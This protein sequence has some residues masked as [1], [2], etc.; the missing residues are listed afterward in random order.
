MSVVR[1]VRHHK[2]HVADVQPKL[3]V[4][5]VRIS[6]RDQ[7]VAE[8]EHDEYPRRQTD[9]HNRVIQER[10]APRAF[11]PRFE[12]NCCFVVT[13]VRHRGEIRVVQT[14]P[15]VL[16]IVYDVDDF[17][18]AKREVL[19][20]SQIENERVHVVRQMI[21]TERAEGRH[22]E[23]GHDD[24]GDDYV[25]HIVAAKFRG[26]RVQNL[27][28]TDPF[29]RFHAEHVLVFFRT[30]HFIDYLRVCECI[31]APVDNRKLYNFNYPDAGCVIVEPSKQYNNVGGMRVEQ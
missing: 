13:P 20:G 18:H 9:K 29:C 31:A 24:H 25:K 23:N 27:P 16:G 2:I 14:L 5:T 15:Q 22:A 12:Y 6:Y 10:Y 30:V 8:G 17:V 1:F 26:A 3:A 28:Q 4:R 19:Y 7:R 21:K 11:P